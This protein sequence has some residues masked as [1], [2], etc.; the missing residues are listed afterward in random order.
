MSAPSTASAGSTNWRTSGALPKP[1]PSGLA[2]VNSAPTN[3]Q[4]SASE[5]ETLL[6]SPM[7]ATRTPWRRPRSCLIVNRSA[8]PCSG[9]SVADSMLSTGPAFTAA[10][11]SSTPLSK[12][13]GAMI[14][15]QFDQQRMQYPPVD[16][17]GKAD[18]LLDRIGAGP[19]LG[20]HAL[21]D[22]ARTDALAQF[23]GGQARH[24]AIFVLD[25]LEQAGRGG[26][27]DDLLG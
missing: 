16:D 6:P 19:K 8:S 17:V 15:E 21:A 18:A 1:N 9:W 2:S 24:Q 10:I 23:G 11:S 14:G 3:A 5:R 20:D 22:R 13:R 12:R 7:N 26:Q 4:P 27:I 25:V